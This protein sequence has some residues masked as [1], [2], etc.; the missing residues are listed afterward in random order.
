LFSLVSAVAGV[1]PAAG[2]LGA[3]EL[4]A[5][6]VC[7]RVAQQVKDVG[8]VP[9]RGPGGIDIAGRIVRVTK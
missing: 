9:P 3:R 4:S 1:R 6:L 5:D 2:P 7:F 8:G